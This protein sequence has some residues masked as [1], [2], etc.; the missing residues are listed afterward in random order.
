M[1]RGRMSVH[2]PGG[3]RVGLITYN[4]LYGMGLVHR[5]TNTSLYSGQALSAS[6]AGQSLLAKLPAP[7]ATPV[8][9]PPRTA[10]PPPP[11]AGR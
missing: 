11:A 9:V 7:T 5:D 6:A 1:Y 3:A 2:A 10:A 4:S 8:P